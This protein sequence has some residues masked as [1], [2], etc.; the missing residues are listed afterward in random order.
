MEYWVSY[1]GG[2]MKIPGFKSR[3]PAGILPPNESMKKIDISE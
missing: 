3:S 2:A 1:G